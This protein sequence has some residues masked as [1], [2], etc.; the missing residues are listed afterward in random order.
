MGC[1]S[2]LREFLFEQSMKRLEGEASANEET[3]YIYLIKLSATD[4]RS[5][6]IIPSH[7]YN[8]EHIRTGCSFEVSYQ[9]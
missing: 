4:K 1:N 9:E 5:W 3:M 8:L 7:L 2:Q 6:L